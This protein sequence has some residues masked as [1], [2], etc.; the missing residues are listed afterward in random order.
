M[1]GY[2]A[3]STNVSFAYDTALQAARDLYSLSGVVNTKHDSRATEATSATDGWDGGHRTTFDTKMT[4]EDTDAESVRGALVTLANK[5]A[6][7]WAAARGEQDRINH[8]RYVQHEKDDDSW[9]E[10]G[11]ELVV[12]EDDYGAPPENPSVPEA[13]D[14]AVSRDPVHPEFEYV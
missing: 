7:E 5:F 14:Y 9:V 3:S 13:P 10:D 6:S 1:G 4:T 8:A 12:G 2:S 11:A